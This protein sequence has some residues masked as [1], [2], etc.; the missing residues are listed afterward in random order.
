MPL[1]LFFILAIL[2]AGGVVGMIVSRDR[3]HSVLFLVLA[4]AALGGVFGLLDAP[5]V[6]AVQVLIYAGAIMVLFVFVVMMIDQRDGRSIEKK[7]LV[8]I[9]AA[10]LAM[11]LFAELLLAVRGILPGM[12][13]AGPVGGA[14]TAG[15]GSLLFEKYL[16]P[17]EI[18][19]ILIIA[20]L[21]GAISLAGK[22]GPK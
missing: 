13:N 3:T 10:V 19:S 1:L 2:S 15:L 22:K 4:F 16:Y 20:A 7:K 14:D 5:F 12:G 6:A 17:L 18:T 11:T 21:T 8:G 9:L